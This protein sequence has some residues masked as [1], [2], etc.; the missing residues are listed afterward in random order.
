MNLVC[1][2]FRQISFSFKNGSN[3]FSKSKRV[4]SLSTNRPFL[5]L[6]FYIDS[7]M[8]RVPVS[9]KGRESDPCFELNRLEFR[10]HTFIKI[11]DYSYLKH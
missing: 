9:T 5:K 4:L 10:W 1:A 7:L 2:N 11:A 8:G 3:D 6:C